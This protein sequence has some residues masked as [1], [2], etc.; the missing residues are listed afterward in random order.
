MADTRKGE[1]EP[2]PRY[3]HSRF[4]ASLDKWYFLTR[5][6]MVEG[7]FQHRACAENMLVEYL[8]KINQV[9]T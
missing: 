8:R 5:E 3:R 4:F 6:G 2:Q 9:I 1:S 7:P